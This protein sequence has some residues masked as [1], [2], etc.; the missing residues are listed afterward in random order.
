MHVDSKPRR[1]PCKTPKDLPPKGREGNPRPVNAQRNKNN[2]SRQNYVDMSE[3]KPL[4]H[5]IQQCGEKRAP[6]SVNAINASQKQTTKQICIAPQHEYTSF[7]FIGEV[8][9]LDLF[10]FPFQDAPWGC[11]AHSNHACFHAQPVLGTSTIPIHYC[12]MPNLEKRPFLFFI[13]ADADPEDRF[14]GPP[15]DT[16]FW[17]T[18]IRCFARSSPC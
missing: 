12:F 16:A 1:L 15:P 18:A 17:M 2:R 11:N 5:A 8:I 3:R 6:I 14:D 7:V 10:P 13:P 4:F 9:L